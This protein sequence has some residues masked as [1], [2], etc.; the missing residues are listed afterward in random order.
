MLVIMIIAV[1]IKLDS[2][3]PV[4]YQQDR[5]ATFGEM[6]SICAFRIMIPDAEAETG[7]K[8]SE[9]ELGGT[10]PRVAR[11]GRFLRVTHLDEIPQLWS[12]PRGE[13]SVVGPRPE[14]PEI[15]GDQDY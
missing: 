10:D 3:R 11:V 14:R 1:V 7:S 12:I 5:T 15:D 2:P 4:L 9:E 13:I 6:F 8:L